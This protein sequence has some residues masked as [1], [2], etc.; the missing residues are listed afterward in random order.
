M[1]NY[2]EYGTDKFIFQKENKKSLVN[3]AK[4]L[5]RSIDLVKLANSLDCT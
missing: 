5:R 3:K 4:S 1:L 2:N